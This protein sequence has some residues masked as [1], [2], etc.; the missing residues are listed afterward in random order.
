MHLCDEC[1]EYLL[2]ARAVDIHF[3][4]AVFPDLYHRPE[5]QGIWI[6]HFELRH[7]IFDGFKPCKF[8]LEIR[9]FVRESDLFVYDLIIAAF[10]VHQVI[11]RFGRHK[12]AFN[13]L[14]GI[15]HSESFGLSDFGKRVLEQRA[16]VEDGVMRYRKWVME[17]T[18]QDQVE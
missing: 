1:I 18:K 8:K 17:M 2:V 13:P 6:D 9:I 12:S 4:H 14:P 5:L 7:R 15:Y 16:A 10:V 11:L 3:A